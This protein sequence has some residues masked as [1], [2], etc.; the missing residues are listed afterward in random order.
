MRI[1]IQNN[2]K[3]PAVFNVSPE[4]WGEALARAGKAEAGYFVSFGESDGEFTA[5]G[6]DI[7]ILISGP[8]TIKHLL[9]DLQPDRA[10]KLK[11]IF[12]VAAGIDAIPADR[13]PPVPYV[14]N[15]GAHAEKAGEFVAMA[16]LMLAGGMPECIADQQN[17]VWGQRFTQ[18]LRGR[19][20]TIL[21]LGAMGGA[22]AE[23]AK[24]FGMHVTGLRT[25]PAPH[26]ACD[27][28]LPTD[29]LDAVLAETDFLII[30]APLTPATRK[31]LNK[32]RIALMPKGAYVINIGRGP[33]I[34]QD[35][36][37]DAL[38]DGFLAGAVL[39]VFDPEPVPADDRVWTT[40]NMIMTPHVSVDDAI[41]YV[42]RSLDIF[43]ANLAALETGKPLLTPVD[44]S[45]GY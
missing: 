38:D 4:Q 45:R 43:F 34:D 42:P 17:K 18:G 24:H 31:I 37:C 22:S 29:D 6:P 12:S 1:H 27:R 30:S 41:S 40:R 19:R 7:D 32:D 21:G 10:P 33:L 11:M 14:N 36:L 23:Q 28:V 8:G 3:Q 13:V 2:P 44:F 26:P 16:L 9:P 5:V 39:D 25:R 15:R 20:A 35:A